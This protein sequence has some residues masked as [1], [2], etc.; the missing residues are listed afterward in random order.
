[1]MRGPMD[2][3]FSRGRWYAS[4][5]PGCLALFGLTLL[6]GV[7]GCYAP[8]FADGGFAC[9]TEQCPEDFYCN[10]EGRAADGQ[11]LRLCRPLPA[12]SVSD[13]DLSFRFVHPVTQAV[14]DAPAFKGDVLKAAVLVTTKNFTLDSTGFGKAPQTG[15]GHYHV[16]LDRPDQDAYIG[17]AAEPVFPVDLGKFAR[18]KHWLILALHNN[19]HSPLEP[20]TQYAVEFVIL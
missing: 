20:W 15:R 16:Y 1:M 10:S 6:S 9:P 5:L 3:R 11:E 19:D 13:P 8:E 12:R 2:T 7:G 14:I 18:G 4:W 17:A